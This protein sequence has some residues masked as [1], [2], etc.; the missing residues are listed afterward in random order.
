MRTGNLL[1]FA[2]D[3][4]GTTDLRNEQDVHRMLE[5]L[6]QTY[7]GLA[8]PG[9]EGGLRATMRWLLALVFAAMAAAPAAADAAVGAEPFSSGAVAKPASEQE[10][11]TWSQAE[12]LQ[13]IL[14]GGGVDLRR[15]GA[16]RL[17]RRV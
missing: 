6:F 1:W 9:Q 8:G 16:D 2:T 5:Q 4:S 10:Q 15:P 13:E 12:E 3:Q 14:V 11:R 7:P 17:R